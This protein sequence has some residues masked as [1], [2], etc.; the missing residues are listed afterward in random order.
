MSITD[1][2]IE[3]NKTNKL[4]TSYRKSKVQRFERTERA[5]RI[6][7]LSASLLLL[8]T[9]SPWYVDLAHDSLSAIRQL[10]F[11]IYEQGA[12]HR[13]MLLNLLV[14]LKVMLS[15]I[16]VFLIAALPRRLPVSWIFVTGHL[17][18]QE[19]IPPGDTNK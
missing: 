18:S 6:A 13:F 17:P 15:L 11:H 16:P 12:L 14:V 7:R 4:K 8:V 10:A 5:E 9:F 1:N 3:K 2:K 19:E